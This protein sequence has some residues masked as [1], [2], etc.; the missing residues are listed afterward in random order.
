MTSKLFDKRRMQMS[1]GGCFP[2]HGLTVHIDRK[3]ANPSRNNHR[4]DVRDVTLRLARQRLD[5]PINVIG[6]V[7]DNSSGHKRNDTQFL[8]T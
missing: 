7:N 8:K 4:N 1:K 5:A 3:G 6:Q 2:L